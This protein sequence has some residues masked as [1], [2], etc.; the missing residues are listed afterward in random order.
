MAT[1]RPHA[2]SPGCSV[3]WN[4]AMMPAPAQVPSQV[5]ESG[6]QVRSMSLK[7]HYTFDKDSRVNCLARHPHTL[8]VRTVP[9]DETASI[10]IVDLRACIHAIM[11]CSPELASPDTDYSIYAVDYSEPNTPLVGQGM[12]SR[13]LDSLRGNGAP[14]KMVIGRVTKNL[15]A[16]F[17]GGNKETL[18]V[19]LTLSA[20]AKPVRHHAY[21]AMPSQDMGMNAQHHPMPVQH[22]NMQ[23]EHQD[24]EPRYVERP[25]EQ[26]MTPSG[27]SEWD[28]FMQSNPQLGHTAQVA[29]VASPV[30]SQGRAPMPNL[31]EAPARRPLAPTVQ[32]DSQSPPLPQAEYQQAMSPAAHEVQRVAP[33]PVEPG[34]QPSRPASRPSSRASSRTRTKKPPTGRPRGRPRKRPADGNTSGAEEPATEGEDAQPKKRARTTK[35]T[36][37]EGKAPTNPFATGP[38]SLR[39][40]ASTS[41]SLRNFRPLASS[42]HEAAGSHLQEVPRA[43][44]PVPDGGPF[45]GASGRNQNASKLRRESTL[46][47]Q[48]SAIAYADLRLQPLSPGQ[49]DGRSP[50]SVAVTPF[51]EG[52]TPDISS[53]PPMQRRAPMIRSS[54]PASSPVLPP[55][56]TRAEDE[57]PVTSLANDDMGDLFGEEPAQPTTKAIEPSRPAAEQQRAPTRAHGVPIQI[58]QIQDG[59]EGQDMVFLRSINGA[60]LP[61]HVPAPYHDQVA[62]GYPPSYHGVPHH[63][64]ALQEHLQQFPPVPPPSSDAPTLPPL[65]DEPAPKRKRAPAKRKPKAKTAVVAEPA[66]MQPTPPPTTD[67][68]RP[69]SPVR[70]QFA[71]SDATLSLEADPEPMR[72]VVHTDSLGDREMVEAP[73]QAPLEST[74]PQETSRQQTTASIEPPTQPAQPPRPA[75]SR[76]FARSQSAG[77]LALPQVPASEPAGPSSLSRSTIAHPDPPAPTMLK[78]ATSSGPLAL[79]MPASD[80]I[81]PGSSN[82]RVSELHLPEPEPSNSFLPP[83]SSPPTRSNK[84]IVKKNAIKQRLEQ[85]INAGE[86]PPFCTNCGNIETPT[87][88]KIWV[89]DQEGSLPEGVEFSEKP[90]MITAFE[91]VERDEKDKVT[92]YRVIKKSLAPKEDK[93]PWQ[94]L[95][96]CNPC[97]IWLCKSKVHRPRDRWDKDIERL[98]QERRK[99]GTGRTVPRPKKPRSKSDPQSNLTSEAYLPTDGLG[100]LEP[101]SPKLPETGMAPTDAPQDDRQAAAPRATSADAISNPGSTHSRG[102]GTVKSPIDLAFDEAV[103][104][105]KRLLF[106]SPRKD[107]EMKRLK[108]YVEGEKQNAAESAPEENNDDEVDS[109]FRSPVMR[110]STPP[111]SGKPNAAAGPFKTPTRPTP[112]HRP[113]TRSVTRSAS[114]SLRSGRQVPESPSQALL[115]PQHTPTKTPRAGAGVPGSVS[116]RRSPRNH[117]GAFEETPISRTINEAFSEFSDP[118]HFDVTENMDLSLLPALDMTS[119]M[120]DYYAFFSTDG[121]MPSSPTQGNHASLEYNGTARDSSRWP[122]DNSAQEHGGDL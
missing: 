76:T 91:V 90:G 2:P 47:Q 24:A 82:L 50:E 81:G 93:T 107:G 7:V 92:K 53:S 14:P 71:Q 1:P 42:S 28:S 8:Q 49:E 37:V 22:H 11:D 10:G 20:S 30:Y 39:V 35:A 117:Q 51:S 65:K 114:K 25:S 101:S 58:F 46:S 73:K 13:A 52:S 122:M 44:T 6:L 104:S 94:E 69:T 83:V 87:W 55:M 120:L 31:A 36:V 38:E 115:L 75:K 77:A 96:L 41:G 56:P 111:P 63:A 110:P 64:G 18:E 100:P 67:A 116:I 17:S 86:L 23:M 103:G 34:E 74:S 12:L 66:I 109:L 80:P 85:A 15:L 21:E 106:P 43:P 113:I 59:P 19:K 98:G 57:P 112:S 9:V 89:Q 102:S 45:G 68:A 79:P 99:K 40:A 48:H 121:M 61:N 16:M 70:N 95:L 118:V 4:G 32:L 26:A 105:T 33:I 88:R 5:D 54:P 78:R 3:G 27:A 97:G 72:G 60:P 108:Q 62:P 84:N 29:R 119:D